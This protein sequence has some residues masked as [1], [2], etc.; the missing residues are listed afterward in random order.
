MAFS[1]HSILAAA[2]QLYRQRTT[3]ASASWTASECLISADAEQFPYEE[4]RA[5]YPVAQEPK[6]DTKLSRPSSLPACTPPVMSGLCSLRDHHRAPFLR[7][8]FNLLARRVAI[9]CVKACILSLITRVPEHCILVARIDAKINLPDVHTA[10]NIRTLLVDADQHLAILVIPS[11]AVDAA[12]NVNE[13]TKSDV[14]HNAPRTTVTKSICPVISPA[15]M[16]MLSFTS[17]T[18]VCMRPCIWDPMWTKHRALRRRPG[19]LR[20]KKD[21]TFSPRRHDTGPHCTQIRLETVP[22]PCLHPTRSPF[23]HGLTGLPLGEA[24]GPP[25]TTWPV[26]LDDLSQSCRTS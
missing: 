25:A 26:D 4:H 14:P 2:N 3:N 1:V 12:Q 9:E 15:T 11:L 24:Q 23:L 18:Q 17:F 6:D 16:T 22:T 10:C 5:P 19:R 7:K 21:G 8:S 20:R 13:G